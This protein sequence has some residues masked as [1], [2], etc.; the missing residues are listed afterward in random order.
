MERIVLLLEGE[1]LQTLRLRPHRQEIL[2]FLRIDRADRVQQDVA[3]TGVEGALHLSEDGPVLFG[4]RIVDREQHLR[5][6]RGHAVHRTVQR[7]GDH[8]GLVPH[9]FRHILQDFV[10]RAGELF[11]GLVVA[12]LVI[13]SDRIAH[14]RTRGVR[15]QAGRRQRRHQRHSDDRRQRRIRP[16]GSR[17]VA[18]RPLVG[19]CE[20]VLRS[21]RHAGPNTGTD[22][23]DTDA[24]TSVTASAGAAPNARQHAHGET[25]QRHHAERDHRQRPRL[26]P[27]P[28]GGHDVREPSGQRGRTHVDQSVQQ[29]RQQ[30]R[31]RVLAHLASGERPFR[32]THGRPATG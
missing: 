14:R 21:R 29:E 16:T 9:G 6:E 2:G 31:Y 22:V 11:G 12:Q 4:H 26:R 17:A 1:H 25:D 5:A 32:E 28:G 3:G 24:G 23:G 15:E 13:G 10:F 18:A 7:V 30:Q 19:D 27:I 20:H 8:G